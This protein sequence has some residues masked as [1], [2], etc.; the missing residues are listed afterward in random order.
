MLQELQVVSAKNTE[1]PTCLNKQELIEPEFDNMIKTSKDQTCT[2][3]HLHE[4]HIFVGQ[5]QRLQ[6]LPVAIMTWTPIFIAALKA[7]TVFVVIL[8]LPLSSV[9]T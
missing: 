9:P 1:Q 8:L 4:L 6:T 3:Q 2:L 5:R 7:F